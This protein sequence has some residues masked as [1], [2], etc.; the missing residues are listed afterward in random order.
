MLRMPLRRLTRNTTRNLSTSDGTPTNPGQAITVTRD[1]T[2]TGRRRTAHNIGYTA[3]HVAIVVLMVS[4][5]AAAF[6]DPSGP[7]VPAAN[8]LPTVIANLQKWVMGILA[9]LATLFLVLG[10]VYRVTAGGDPAQVEKSNT[11][12]K[13]ALIG[14]ALAVLA[15]VL[16]EVVK[17][18]VGG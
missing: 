8:D 9:A 14:Y 7:V 10:G 16:L 11:Q 2:S 5:P 15:P 1:P 13:N 4:V 12:F 6:A 3:A 17:S 18:V